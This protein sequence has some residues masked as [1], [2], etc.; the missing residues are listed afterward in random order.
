MGCGAQEFRVWRQCGSH[1][2]PVSVGTLAGLAKRQADALGAQLLVRSVLERSYPMKPQSVFTTPHSYVAM[3][4]WY[5]QC[6]P[7]LESD[8]L[9][10]GFSPSFSSIE[11]AEG[12]AHL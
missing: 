7:S 6:G 12:G 5:P 4:Q 11:G 8:W 3:A 2:D 1:L 10:I 9:A